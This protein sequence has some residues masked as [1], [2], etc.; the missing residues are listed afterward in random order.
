MSNPE[1]KIGDSVIYIAHGSADGK[2]PKAAHRA[3]IV[4]EAPKKDALENPANGPV[5][6][7]CVM[8]PTGL[9]FLQD[10][11]YDPRGEQGGTW[12]TREIAEKL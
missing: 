5:V 2:Y 9:F 1:P 12:L 8:N 4:T 6:S 11:P 7:L 3:A 10:V